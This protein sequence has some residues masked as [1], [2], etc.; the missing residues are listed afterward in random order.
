MVVVTQRWR[1][2]CRQPRRS[3]GERVDGNNT[4]GMRRIRFVFRLGLGLRLMKRVYI[5]REYWVLGYGFVGN[6]I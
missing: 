4:E 3:S 5:G 1:G 6:R 2:A